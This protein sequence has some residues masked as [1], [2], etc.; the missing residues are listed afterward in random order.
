[1]SVH[2]SYRHEPPNFTAY[3]DSLSKLL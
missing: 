2:V 3:M 1:M